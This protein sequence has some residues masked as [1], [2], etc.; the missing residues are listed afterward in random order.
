MSYAP[1]PAD[2]ERAQFKK[3]L[4]LDAGRTIAQEIHPDA[5]ID[6]LAP[7]REAVAFLALDGA[8][9]A[10]QIVTRGLEEARKTISVARK[11][12]LSKKIAKSVG[13]IERETKL[14]R[15]VLQN[16]EIVMGILNS[17]DKASEPFRTQD[18]TRTPEERQALM[19]LQDATTEAA[20]ALHQLRRT[21][22][23]PITAHSTP[24]VV[25]ADDEDDAPH[26]PLPD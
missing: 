23:E 19:E 3:Q 25:E 4:R 11:Y 18:G 8:A 1:K 5:G 26:I 24:V 10:V 15:G 17:A 13:D 2:I 16:F 12:R 14:I 9:Q 21:M 20:N 7:K 6:A 22:P